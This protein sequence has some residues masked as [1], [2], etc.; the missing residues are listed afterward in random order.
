VIY[1]GTTIKTPITAITSYPFVSKATAT[2]RGF[3]SGATDNL[4]DYRLTSLYN[5]TG[6]V[7][8]NS[9]NI[10]LKYI[11]TTGTTGFIDY[12]VGTDYTSSLI[13]TGYTQTVKAGDYLFLKYLQYPYY[14]GNTTNFT[15][16]I[17]NTPTQYLMYQI[18]SVNSGISYDLSGVTNNS[19]LNF[20]VVI[21]YILYK[22]I[23]YLNYFIF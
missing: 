11:Q 6:I 20:L 19:I 21:I 13:N 3:F 18:T 10:N 17:D 2:E 12:N 14:T 15:P 23:L 8:G 1:N 16:F 7:T 5:I 4:I 22:I 9:N